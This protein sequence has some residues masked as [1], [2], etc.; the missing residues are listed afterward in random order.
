MGGKTYQVKTLPINNQFLTEYKAIRIV[1]EKF[2]EHALISD[3]LEEDVQ[4]AIRGIIKY[5][6]F[7]SSHTF[8]E[9][10]LKMNL[11]FE[12]MEIL[13]L[14][15]IDEPNLFS[16]WIYNYWENIRYYFK[17]GFIAEDNIRP[18]TSKNKAERI[19]R[20]WGMPVGY[21]SLKDE[22]TTAVD[23]IEF[24]KVL[25]LIVKGDMRDLGFEQ[26]KPYNIPSESEE[27]IRPVRNP[28]KVRTRPPPSTPD[29]SSSDDSKGGQGKNPRGSSDRNREKSPG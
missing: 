11:M 6:M 18:T 3:F 2:R 1:M 13:M 9:E 4:E 28:K 24:Q 20:D 23:I 22:F 21:K 25:D 15:Y 29:K 16:Y 7:L 10:D 17:I 27:S 12:E 5:F 8:T 14:L 26:S 19:K